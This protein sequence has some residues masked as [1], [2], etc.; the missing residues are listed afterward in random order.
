[1][2]S[3][4]VAIL[5]S[6]RPKQVKNFVIFL[7]M[8]FSFNESWVLN[9]FLEIFFTSFNAFISF[10]FMSSAIYLFNDSMDVELDIN[11]PTKK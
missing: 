9:E 10:V 7:P 11:H 3:F 4:F 1:M 5:K 2:I 6:S 8:I